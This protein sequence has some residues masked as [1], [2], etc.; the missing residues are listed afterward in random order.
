MDGNAASKIDLRFVEEKIIFLICDCSL[1]KRYSFWGLNR[2]EATEFIGRLKYI[3]KMTWGQ[4][5]ALDREHGITVEN[6]NTESFNMVNQQNTS[7]QKLTEQ[8]YFHFRIDQKGL[9]RV[10][11]YQ[12]N[13]FFVSRTLI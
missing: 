11:G 8:Y 9:S 12:K 6:P 5:A 3:E 1:D 7:S 13:H 10:F 4:F 2:T